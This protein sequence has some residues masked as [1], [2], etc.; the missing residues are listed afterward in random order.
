MKN[1][2]LFHRIAFFFLLFT[3]TCTSQVRAYT[4]HRNRKVDS[5]EL[6]LRNHLPTDKADQIRLYDALAWG[7]LEINE[8]KSTQYARAGLAV[9]QELEA[10]KSI[11]NFHRLLG[12]HHWGNARYSQAE[13]ELKL[14]EEAVESMRKC[15]KYDDEDIDDQASALYGT[16]GNLYN[17]LGQGAKALEYYHRALHL[18]V[19]YDWKESQV[20]AYENMAE[21]YYCMG[22]LEHAREYYHQADSVAQLS[23]DPAMCSLAQKGLAKMAKREG[24]FADAWRYAQSTYDYLFAHPEEE[25]SSR[26]DILIEM[27]DIAI[28]EG[29]WLKAE[30]LL[31]QCESLGKD[32]LKNHAGFLY[33]KGLLAAHKG[34]WKE[35]EQYAVQAEAADTD[36]PDLAKGTYQLL[37]DVYAHLNHPERSK[38]YLT[39]ADSIQTAWSNYAYQASLTEQ[40]TRFE[41]EKKDLEIAT[42]AQEKMLM[43]IIV[44]IGSILL[45]VLAVV[46]IL[47]HRN[48]KR[49]KELLATK[50]ALETETREREIIAKDLHDGLG[51][52]LSLLKL[53]IANKEQDEALHLV[54]ES[55]REMRR[56]AHHIMPAELQQNGLVTSLSNFAISVPGAHFHYYP[57]GGAPVPERFP[58]EIEL[59]LYRCA[60]ELVNNAIKHASADRIDIQLMS[61]PSQVVLTVSD[62][63]KGFDPEQDTDGMG[64]KGI[65]NRIAQYQGEMNVISHPEA[66][67]EIHIAFPL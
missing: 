41:T 46:L 20:I 31:G 15:G 14:A 62:N 64:L 59:V 32:L 1:T 3:L 6:V 25:G 67:T 43:R 49:Q 63:G 61:Q 51:G 54:D 40:E 58:S 26:S 35:A 9:A 57:A 13:T 36:A 11:T 10:Y 28:E 47:S 18:F 34:Q 5:L 44:C 48:H 23:L 8:Q 56:V 45:L 37:S 12:M 17:T 27:A 52:M 39:K 50:V 2:Y 29:N 60:Y 19:K 22:N 42:L 16:L 55:A 53:K 4:D 38:Y 65:R 30:Q 21:L 33:Y 7:Y 66:G 24:N